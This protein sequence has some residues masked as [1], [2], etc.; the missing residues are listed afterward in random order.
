MAH[1]GGRKLFARTHL[2]QAVRVAHHAPALDRREVSR[3]M[4]PLGFRS[5]SHHSGGAL[6][7]SSEVH[8]QLLQLQFAARRAVEVEQVVHNNEE[9]PGRVLDAGDLL[10]LLGRQWRASQQL[11]HCNHT[12]QRGAADAVTTSSIDECGHWQRARTNLHRRAD[13]DS[14]QLV[15]GVGEQARDGVAARVLGFGLHLVCT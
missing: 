11:G 13:N 2:L 10:C 1:A 6:D 12:I 4:L 3:Q 8:G 5:S 15:A 7:N 14:P 9:Q